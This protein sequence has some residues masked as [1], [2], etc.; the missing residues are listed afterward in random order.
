MAKNDEESAAIALERLRKR[1][2]LSVTDL[3]LGAGYKH[4]SGVQ[5]YLDPTAYREA[6]FSLKITRRLADALVGKGEPPIS[7]GEI[8]AVLAGTSPAQGSSDEE[9]P[10]IESNVA[11][12][13]EKAVLVRQSMV[14]DIPLLGTA[15][16][17]NSGDFRFNGETVDYVRRPPGIERRKGIFAIWAQGESMVPWRKPGDLV[18]VD[19]A[20]PPKIGDYVVLEC[21]PTRPGEPGDA[22]LKKLEGI[23][24][25]KIILSEH[26]PDPKRRIEVSRAKVK[27]IYR[28]VDWSEL[29]GA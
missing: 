21:L 19:T 20:R 27:N 1:A 15:A 25:N 2:G 18:Y 3:A 13:D 6:H 9:F 26:N 28:V 7:L 24:P 12:A 29:L 16:A 14:Q 22:Y 10:K 23:T 5:R 4:A 8:Y 11:D 17:G